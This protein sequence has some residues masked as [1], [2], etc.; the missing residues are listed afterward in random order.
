MRSIL[1]RSEKGQAL[2]EFTIILPILL[3]LLFGIME[4]GRIYSTG[5]IMNHVAR[6][7]VRIGSTGA[8]DSQI[9]EVIK[10]SSPTLDSTQLAISIMPEQL[11]RIRGEELTVSV[12][13]PVRVLAPFISVITGETVTVSGYSVMRIE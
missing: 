12:S 11:L 4:F 10:N 9:I 6:E 7:G 5:L 2:I 8:S 13:Y 3:L 1:D